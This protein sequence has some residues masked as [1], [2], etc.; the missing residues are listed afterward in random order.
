[1]VMSIKLEDISE[2]VLQICWTV[3]Q[4]VIS[5][6]EDRWMRSVWETKVVPVEY[7]IEG[8]YPGR[9]CIFHQFP[10]FPWCPPDSLFV[11]DEINIIL[12][13]N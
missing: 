7:F 6:P 8:L 2:G 11:D 3:Q 9:P 10:A 1:M 12:Q 13:F 5:R 4:S